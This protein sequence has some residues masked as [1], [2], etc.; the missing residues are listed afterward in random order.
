MCYPLTWVWLLQMATCFGHGKHKTASA[1]PSPI[2]FCTMLNQELSQ[3]ERKPNTKLMHTSAQWMW[4]MNATNW[5]SYEG[6]RKWW[7][8]QI[9]WFWSPK[10]EC[11]M[12]LLIP[13]SC[14]TCNIDFLRV[15][16]WLR[17]LTYIY[18]EHRKAQILPGLLFVHTPWMLGSH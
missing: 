8:P 15:A 10:K 6:W 11:A 17:N 14:I 2:Y 1:V 7:R 18:I 4:T 12:R 13:K 3:L 16:D 5:A 9:T